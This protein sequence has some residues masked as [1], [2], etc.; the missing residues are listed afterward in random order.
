MGYG[1]WEMMVIMMMLLR[2]S[3]IMLPG[4][5]L[6]GK[7]GLLFGSLLWTEGLDN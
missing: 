7:E 1:R 4:S 2:L 3:E 5:R 6:G